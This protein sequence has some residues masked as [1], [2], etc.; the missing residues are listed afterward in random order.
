LTGEIDLRGIFDWAELYLV[1]I[2]LPILL[3]MDFRMLHAARKEWRERKEHIEALDTNINE[4]KESTE[5]LTRQD[6]ELLILRGVLT[7][8]KRIYCYWHS[9]HPVGESE[10]FRKIN[11]GL[12]QKKKAGVDVRLVVAD[13]PSRIAPAYELFAEGVEVEFKDSLTVSDLRFSIFDHKMSVFGV[14]ETSIPDGKPSRHGVDISSR[15]LNAMLAEHFV[16]ETDK[17]PGF[18][19]FVASRA[20]KVLEDPTNS[21]AMVAEQLRIEQ[22]V[23]EEA[24]PEQCKKKKKE[25]E[26]R[27]EEEGA[28]PASEEENE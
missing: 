6:Y 3:V 19:K 24:C 26:K 12:I 22:S 18:L 5:Q 14:P 23:I 28:G 13:D 7:A 2:L 4:I 16:I 20:C 17:V 10:N 21:I 11:E 1:P 27:Q 8:E 15:K 9:L 25:E